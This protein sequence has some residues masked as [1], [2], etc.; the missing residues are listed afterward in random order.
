MNLSADDIYKIKS[1]LLAY[2]PNLK[3]SCFLLLFVVA[4]YVI[5]AIVVIQTIYYVSLILLPY[6][7]EWAH[8]FYHNW[9][10]H[11]ELGLTSEYSWVFLLSICLFVFFAV[12]GVVILGRNSSYMPVT[13]PH[14]SPL[15]WLLLV[16]FILS[17]NVSVGLLTEW[18]PNIIIDVNFQTGLP[19]FL[20]MVVIMPLFEEWL[21]RGI[22]L[23]GLLTHYSPLKAIVW[24]SV[25]FG[26]LQID[27][28]AAVS[29]F[30]GALAIGWVYWRTRSLWLCIFMHATSNMVEFL[31]KFYIPGKTT[32][33]DLIGN[34]F[35]AIAIAL[36]VCAL[37]W[38][39]I[40]KIIVPYDATSDM[41]NR[42]EVNV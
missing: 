14:Q 31:V 30:C 6:L 4:S 34:Y 35:M 18:I 19:R 40:K 13:P 15:L 33:A 1:R 41:R 3:Q 32:F 7:P 37:T 2:S 17:V 24:S 23:K 20:S 38:V 29:V 12:A 5:A 36:F 9:V 25:M 26:V 27:P 42:Q 28:N 22:I 16:P 8:R 10:W 11:R 39:L 21:G